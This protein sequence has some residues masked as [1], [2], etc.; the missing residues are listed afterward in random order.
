MSSIKLGK[1]VEAARA[2]RLLL[3]GKQLEARNSVLNESDDDLKV[4]CLVVDYA[5]N[6]ELPWFRESQPGE[7]YYYTPLNI[8][9]LGVVNVVICKLKHAFDCVQLPL[10]VHVLE[11]CHSCVQSGNS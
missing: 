7:V 5:Q 2:Q 11:C 9:L 8:F 6:M 1:H 10:K 4:R 3:N